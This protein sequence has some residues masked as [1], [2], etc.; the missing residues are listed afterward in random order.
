MITVIIIT[1]NKLG[2]A[3]LAIAKHFY[4]QQICSFTYQS[5]YPYPKNVNKATKYYTQIKSM[6]WNCNVG[7]ENNRTT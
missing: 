7:F 5:P 3:S 1:A 6:F 4:A 2:E